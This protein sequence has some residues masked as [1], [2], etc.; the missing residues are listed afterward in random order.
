MKLQEF[1]NLASIVIEIYADRVLEN[2]TKYRYSTQDEPQDE[3]EWWN[4]FIEYL[5]DDKRIDRSK[6]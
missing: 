2:R 1:K 6:I 5:H 3:K 4:D